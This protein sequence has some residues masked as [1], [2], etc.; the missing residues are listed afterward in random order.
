MRSS[1]GFQGPNS[2]K[3]CSDSVGQEFFLLMIV[4][5]VNGLQSA[6]GTITLYQTVRSAYCVGIYLR[7]CL[8]RLCPLLTVAHTEY[9]TWRLCALFVSSF[10]PDT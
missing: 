8:F 9:S 1:C 5:N 2:L 4:A 3:I 6:L 7:R 10:L